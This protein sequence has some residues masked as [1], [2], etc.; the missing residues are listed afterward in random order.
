MFRTEMSAVYPFSPH[1]FTLHALALSLVQTRS[2]LL[3]ITRLKAF[4]TRLNPSRYF[5]VHWA[6]S[7]RFGRPR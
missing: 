1:S 2:N 6:L 3:P 7:R 4:L 5:V